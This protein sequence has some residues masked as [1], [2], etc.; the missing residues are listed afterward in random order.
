M[1]LDHPFQPFYEGACIERMNSSLK[2]APELAERTIPKF[3]AGCRRITPGDGYLEAL[4]QPNC[5]D[6]WDS[7]ES[8]TEK[9]I[10]TTAGEE[11][12]DLIV[13]A[14][15]YDGSWLPQ[16]K[17]VGR[18]GA[19]LEDMWKEDPEAFFTTQVENLPNYGMINGPNVPISHGSVLQQMSWVC[20]YLLHWVKK[21]N[22]QDI[23]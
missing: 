21:I 4:Q 17:L 22:R 16:W 2:N 18:D 5:T 10:K 15:G 3:R 20:D 9:G 19:T 8:I 23:K 6:C 11:E 7:I 12:F 1:C 14:T 13:C